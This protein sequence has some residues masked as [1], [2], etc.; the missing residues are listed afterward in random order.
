MTRSL[1]IFATL[2]HH[3]KLMKRWMVFGNHVLAKSTL[4]ARDRELLI[5]RTGWNCRAPYEWGQHVAIARGVGITDDEIERVAAGP[6]APG[7]DPFEALPAARGRRAAQRPEPHRRDL[8]RRSRQR[9]DE[10]HLLDLVFTVG[11]YHLVSMA[12]NSLR[13]QRDDGV[14]GVPMPERD[15]DYSVLSAVAGG[16]R[17]AMQPGHRGD[18][19]PDHE[20]GGIIASSNAPAG[21]RASPGTPRF[22]AK[23]DHTHRPSAVPIGQPDDERDADERRRLPRH[24]GRDLPPPEAEGLEDREVASAPPDRAHEQIGDARRSRA[25]RARR[26][27]RRGVLW[28]RE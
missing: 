28:T 18:E 17:L 6:D 11:Q 22:G 15:A 12:L 8:R 20:R 3:P 19:V 21:V 14:T 1:N 25:A 23:V 24:G 16:E 2:A 27:A 4:S 5:L 9:Y 7:W 13:V 26:P 10:Q